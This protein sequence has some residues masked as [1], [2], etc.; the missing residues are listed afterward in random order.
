MYI[1]VQHEIE[2]TGSTILSSV[3]QL[4]EELVEQAERLEGEGTGEGDSGAAGGNGNGEAGMP[5]D[6]TVSKTMTVS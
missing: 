2:L 5:L 4:I 3:E 6:A 1:P